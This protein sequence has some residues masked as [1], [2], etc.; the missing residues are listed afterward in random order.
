MRSQRL[1][2]AALAGLR[3]LLAWDE[4]EELCDRKPTLEEV[5][6]FVDRVGGGEEVREEVERVARRREL[7][8]GVTEVLDVEELRK[9]LK[10]AEGVVPVDDF[11]TDLAAHL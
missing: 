3:K 1:Q 2:P 11:R 6:T 7:A 4:G 10:R 8:E 5:R 9:G